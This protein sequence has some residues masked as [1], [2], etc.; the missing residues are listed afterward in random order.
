MRWPFPIRYLPSEQPRY[1]RRQGPGS[2]A[3]RRGQDGQPV[4]RMTQPPMAP[5]VVVIDDDEAVRLS[6]DL[7]LVA[8]GFRCATFGSAEALLAA[9]MP[10]HASCLVV[11]LRM[12]G[13]MDGIELVETLRRQGH[14]VPSLLV[15]GHGDI[16][17]AV[18]AMRAGAEDFIE[19]PYDV[20]ALV[21]AI[22]GAIE[23]PRSRLGLSNAALER[24]AQLS[25]REREVLAALA[26]GH[27]N[28]MIAHLLGISAR[29]VEVHRSHL[30]Q[31]LGVRSLGEAV[32]VAVS[33]GLVE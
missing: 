15:S 26:E 13:G 33:A 1:A 17:Q 12:P 21:A 5:L 27:P 22:R 31:K 32:R 4:S 24:V 20:A 10:S 25:V 2:R 16:T 18:R 3:D 19:K 14:A 6:L 9:G 29:T 8:A 28:K 11:D 23:H 7:F 30:M